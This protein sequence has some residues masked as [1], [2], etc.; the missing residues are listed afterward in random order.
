[1]SQIRR[2]SG[3]AGREKGFYLEL[4]HIVG[5]LRAIAAMSGT[6]LL[7]SCILFFI[8]ERTEDGTVAYLLTIFVN[9]VAFIGSVLG[10]WILNK[11]DEELTQRERERS[12][13]RGKSKE[14]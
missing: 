14:C 9:L 4:F 1:M 8:T 5:F 3:S 7:F 11:K 13:N 12:R 6:L 10:A 2:N